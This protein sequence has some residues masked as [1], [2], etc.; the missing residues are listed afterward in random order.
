MNRNATDLFIYYHS[1]KAY[2]ELA[3]KETIWNVGW[4]S[5][6][7]SFFYIIVS[8]F[9]LLRVRCVIKIFLGFG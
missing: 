8:V 4:T 2:D 3:D 9:L 6:Q 5:C 7:Q 1:L